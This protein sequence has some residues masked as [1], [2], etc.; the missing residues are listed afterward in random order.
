MRLTLRVVCRCLEIFI[1]WHG[2]EITDTSFKTERLRNNKVEKSASDPVLIHRC[3][4]LYFNL[5]HASI[6]VP[7]RLPEES[8]DYLSSILTQK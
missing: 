5:L 6:H 1:D 8:V 2:T 3:S 4:Q 7:E